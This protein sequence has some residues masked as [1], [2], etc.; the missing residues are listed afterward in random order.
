MS[1][2]PCRTAV[3][4]RHLWGGRIQSLR[5]FRRARVVESKGWCVGG[6]TFSGCR[7]VAG[8]LNRLVGLMVGWLVCWFVWLACRRHIWSVDRLALGLEGFEHVSSTS[9]ARLRRASARS[10]ARFGHV[11]CPS[12]VREPRLVACSTLT[13]CS[14]TPPESQ[15]L[16]FPVF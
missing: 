12:C 2:S 15:K 13:F 1:L 7:G 8:L 10:L 5:A 11:P 14:Q 4:T 16:V 3:L 6:F 9:R